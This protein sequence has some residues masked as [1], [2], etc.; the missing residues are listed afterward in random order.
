MRKFA[1]EIFGSHRSHLQD[2][3]LLVTQ[4]RVDLLDVFVGLVLDFLL[5]VLEVVLG[6]FPILLQFSA[7]LSTN[8]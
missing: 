3:F 5:R 2:F 7:V 4:N 1:L 6:D 8:F